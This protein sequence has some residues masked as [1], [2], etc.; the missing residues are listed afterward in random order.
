M[1]TVANTYLN[2]LLADA[3]YVHNIDPNIIVGTLSENLGP[4]MTPTLADYIA[5]N[6][7]VVTQ[8]QS[9]DITGS[10]FDATVW[11]QTGGKL[12]VSMRGTE[13][14]QD[15]FVT[16]ADLAITGNARAQIVDMVNW[17]FRET[18]AAGQPVRQIDYL[19]TADPLAPDFIEV[20]PAVGTGRITAADLVGGIEVN[21]HSLG[22]YLAAA[23]TRLFGSQAHVTHTSTFNSA[24]FAPGSEAVF[25][26]LQNLI[27]VSYGLG[28]FPNA[29]EQTNYFAQNGLNLT[30]NNSWF[31]QTGNR[32]EL[33]N[34]SSA[35]QLPNHFMY[36]LT[37]ALALANAMGQL[38]P[39]LTTAKMNTL[40]AAGSNTMQASIEGMFD[41]L[42]RIFK[43]NAIFISTVGDV[44]DSAVS[45]VAYQTALDTLQKSQAFIDLRVQK[46]GQV[47]HCNIS[48]NDLRKLPAPCRLR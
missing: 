18:G 43:G 41:A 10:G 8:I 7:S 31:T 13:P 20:A 4:R 24:G 23:F 28:R 19:F 25:V 34:E 21:G 26:E 38:D 12:F 11:R 42:L 35:T 5:S 37:D 44:A 2:A 39:T 14:G 1:T 15:L 17:W 45:R 3:T 16:D 46:W 47:L 33:F 32:V 30:T 40:F 22:G 36:K 9:G 48:K 29:S 6:F 27:G